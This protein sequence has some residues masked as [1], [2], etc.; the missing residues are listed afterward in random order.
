M[1]DGLDLAFAATLEPERAVAYLRGKGLGVSW[2]WHDT[3]EAAHARAFVVAKAAKLDVLST[4]REAV[5]AAL[6]KGLT[7]RQFVRELEPRLRALGWW[8]RRVVAGPDGDDGEVQL[9]SPRRLKTIYDTNMR[10]AY[11]ASRFRAQAANAASR[12]YLQY[13]S[14]DDDRVRPS[15]RAMSGRVYRHDDPIWDTH[16]PPNGFNCRC[17]VRALT[18]RQV[19]ARGLGVYRTGTADGGVLR[20]VEQ[21]AGV[22]RRTGEEIRRPATEY[23]FER[24]AGRLVTLTPDPGWNYNPGRTGAPFGPITGDPTRLRPLAGGAAGSRQLDLPD[25]PP[26]RRPPALPPA[27]TAAAAEEQI[28]RAINGRAGRLVRLDDGS[29]T[30]EYAV[31]RTPAGDVTLTD[32]FVRHVARKRMRARERF[33]RQILPTLSDPFEVWLQPT[34]RYD[35]RLTYEPVFIGDYG[36]Y[37]VAQEHRDATVGWTFY[38]PDRVNE[39]RSGYLLYR[40]ASV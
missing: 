35:G 32:G 17:T 2:D 21:V 11:A 29:G 39:R 23:V 22:N 4:L 10:T 31:V 1:A 26:L 13:L 8:G 15:H 36:D 25:L 38:R 14:M 34:V 33:A 3:W 20:P 30:L 12:P 6:A 7:R 9:G 5:D 27:P 24:G 28:R 40:R 37:V 18:P 19:R 16:Y